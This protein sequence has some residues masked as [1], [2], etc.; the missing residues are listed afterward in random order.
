[1]GAVGGGESVGNI[2]VGRCNQL[3]GESFIAFFLFAVEAQ[4][5]QKQH[6]VVAHGFD[7]GFHFFADAVVN[8]NNFFAECLFQVADDVR[9]RVFH[10][11]FA[12]RPAEVADNHNLGAFFHQFFD[13]R[14]R[15]VDAGS[16]GYVKVFVHRNVQVGAQHDDF[17]VQIA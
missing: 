3:F 16:V 17:A 14:N 6:F 9:K 4:V 7:S 15:A 13:G 11:A 1:M 2:N 8:E 5:F 10:V 12:F